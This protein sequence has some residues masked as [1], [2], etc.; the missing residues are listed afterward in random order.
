MLKS[1]KRIKENCSFVLLT[2]MRTRAVI[3]RAFRYGAQDVLPYP[4]S[5][6]V[7]RDTILHRLEAQPISDSE[8]ELK[9]H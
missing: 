2:R 6:V 3:E 9:A 1:L 4:V 5:S 8:G 7:L